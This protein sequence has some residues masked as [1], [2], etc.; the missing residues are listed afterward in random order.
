MSVYNEHQIPKHF[1]VCAVGVIWTID[2]GRG[3]RERHNIYFTSV[4]TT[5]VYIRI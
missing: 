5:T 2:L 1:R 3:G 4:G